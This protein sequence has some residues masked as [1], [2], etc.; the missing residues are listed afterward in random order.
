V[1][2]SAITLSRARFRDLRAN[3]PNRLNRYSGEFSGPS[4][5]AKVRSSSA[6]NSVAWDGSVLLRSHS[7]SFSPDRLC[8]FGPYTMLLSVH[9]E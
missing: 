8:G 2:H 9:D 7:E 5:V 3:V 6:G 4:E 1:A